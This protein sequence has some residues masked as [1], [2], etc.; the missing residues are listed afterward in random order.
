MSRT[1]S[2]TTLISDV[3]A[4]G[5]FGGA[6]VRHTDAQITR[7]INQAIQA[8]RRRVSD[9]G[10]THYLVSSSGTLGSAPTSPYPFYQLDLSALSPALVRT[11]G[12]DVTFPSGNVVSLDYVPFNERARYGSASQGGTPVAW[13]HF[14]TDQVAILPAPDQALPYVVWYL[15]KYTDLASGSDTFDGVEG[16]EDWVVWEVVCQVIARDQFPQAFA[17]ASALRAEAQANVTHGATKV[18]QAGGAHVGQDSF[19]RKLTHFL[20]GRN[21]ARVA[22]GGP[23][24]PAPGTVTNSM[25]SVMTGPSVKGVM[26]GTTYPQD[27][28]VATLTT[29]LSL[30]GTTQRGLVPPPLSV[31]N[32]FLRDDGTWASAA[33]SSSAGGPSG[34]VQF[35]SGGGGFGGASGFRVLGTSP[36]L[37]MR[38]EGSLRLTGGQIEVGSGTTRIQA[39]G[40]DVGN[41]GIVNVATLVAQDVSVR[42]LLVSSGI[43]NSQ[44]SPMASGTVKAQLGA[45]AVPSDVPVATLLSLVPTFSSNFPGVVPGSGGGSTNFLRAD[46]TWAAPPGGGS[47][48]FA[49]GSGGLQYAGNQAVSASTNWTFQGSGARLHSGV[50]TG[51]PTGS[52]SF[53]AA[54]LSSEGDFTIQGRT[55]KYEAQTL[56]NWTPSGLG[57]GGQATGGVITYGRASGTISLHRFQTAP[58]GSVEF[59]LG[60]SGPGSLRFMQ[61]GV[62]FSGRHLRA[63]SLTITDGIA[64]TELASM[65]SGTV[66]GQLGPAGTPND[67]S[68]ATLHAFAPSFTSAQPGVV[69]PSGGGTINY[70]RADGTW[71]SPPGGA[72]STPGGDTGYVQYRD[73]VGGFQGASGVSIVASGQALLFGAASG[74]PSVGDIR[75]RDASQSSIVGLGRGNQN[76][77]LW[78]YVPSGAGGGTGGYITYGRGS[79]SV[80]MHRFQTAPS[81]SIEFELG[82][83]GPGSLR[84]MQTGVDFSGRHL[85]TKSLT[86]TDG[87]NNSELASMATGTVKGQLGPNGTPND[88]SIATL[89]AFAPSF[90]STQPGVVP[91]S[92]GGTTNYLSAAGSWTAPSGAH[93]FPPAAGA[94]NAQLA[95]MASGTVKGQ[96]G[97]AGT[98]NDVSIATLHAF[99]PTFTSTQRG[100]VPQSGGGTTNFLRADGT[101][102]AP[103]GG[104][105]TPG[106]ADTNLQYNSAGSFGGASGLNISAPGALGVGVPS[107]L[108]GVGDVRVASG[109]NVTANLPSGIGGVA[110]R[111]TVLDWSG[112]GG[113]GTL[114]LGGASG[115]LGTY[116]AEVATG[117]SFQ[118]AVG[119]AT[120]TTARLLPTGLDVSQFHINAKSITT[121]NINGLP[122]DFNGLKRGLDIGNSSGL[123]SASG[124]N[125]YLPRAAGS[126]AN[127]YFVP[128]GIVGTG[129]QFVTL[130][131]TGGRGGGV[132]RIEKLSAGGHNFEVRTP[133]GD[134]LHAFPSGSKGWADFMF[135]KPSATAKVFQLAGHA[136]LF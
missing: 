36:S 110:A 114:Q 55:T 38:L 2:L 66:K 49:G 45:D 68:I 128:S 30:F 126:G 98:P 95:S 17:T 59:E 122:F 5:D 27:V 1:A 19:G 24:L 43:P 60:P 94:T 93:Q 31:S 21:P 115:V 42:G 15:P 44:L 102:A 113:S 104:S 40:I 136:D 90:T 84:F 76:Q 50:P 70:L 35:Q 39:S 80:Q 106:G 69:P 10:S 97:P 87:I 28:R 108:P 132:I 16:W 118:W 112:G 54:D 58:S 52:V 61:T 32:L 46:G 121:Q 56:Y 91:P 4:K 51:T 8:F 127:R 88:I 130:S 99:A 47:S 100:L 105:A 25:L 14:R 135:E 64:N 65:A 12:I 62:D 13:S 63:K 85:R 9:E 119:G 134:V 29:L 79:G 53:A 72:A 107:F 89:H 109:F 18:T 71:S 48:A 120:A 123:L 111:Q 57:F 78:N 83:S 41:G 125:L 3:R 103:P 81:G 23:V 82:P 20:G 92:G 22:A 67:V 26:S 129:T 77:T 131:P 74:A 101:W 124:L 73:E 7:L 6:S 34:A 116:R 117:G 75:F 37:I 96:L 133:T 11:Y 86:V 33:G